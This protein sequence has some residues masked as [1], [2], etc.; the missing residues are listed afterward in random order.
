MAWLLNKILP[1]VSPANSEQSDIEFGGD[2]EVQLEWREYRLNI[3][4]G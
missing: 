4:R 2:L 1:L 3:N